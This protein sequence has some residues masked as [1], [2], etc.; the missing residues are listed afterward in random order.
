M[1]QVQFTGFALA[2]KT[3]VLNNYKMQTGRKA[4]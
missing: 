2:Q 4:E 1:E 3:Q